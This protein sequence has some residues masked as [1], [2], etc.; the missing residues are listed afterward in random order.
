MAPF[1]KRLAFRDKSSQ[2]DGAVLGTVLSTLTASLRGFVGVELLLRAFG[3]AVKEVHRGPEQVVEVGLVAERSV[4]VE[5]SF[6][7]E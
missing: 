3:G 1:N 4:A 7:M 6:F 2:F 5:L